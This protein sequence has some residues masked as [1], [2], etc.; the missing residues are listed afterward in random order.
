MIGSMILAWAACTGWAGA[1]DV[2]PRDGDVVKAVLDVQPAGDNLL[3]DDAWRPWQEGFTRQGDHFLCDNGA[4]AQ[5]QRGAS[6]SVMLNQTE[7]QPLVAV[8]W[9]RA[10]G[11]EGPGGGDYALYLDLVYR[12]GTP[13]WG[14]IAPFDRGTHD[15][16]RRQLVILPKKPIRSLSFHMLLR[17]HAGKAEF[18]GAELRPLLASEGAC[19]FDGV[20]VVPKQPPAEGF[21]VRDVA[22][23]SAF[24]RIEREALG[25]RL[26]VDPSESGDANVFDI[27]LSDTTG[28]DRAVTLVYAI[29]VPRK[30][31]TWF[32]DPRRAEP[33]EPRREYRRTGQFRAGANGELSRYPLAAVAAEGRATALAIDMT[34][35]AYFRLA[36]SSGTGEL[37]LAY[38]I[39]LTPEKPSVR[40][41]F[42]RY[43]FDA[44]WGFRSALA[45]YYEVFAAQFVTRAERQGL[46]MPFA[47]ISKVKGWE[48]FGFTFK[49][50][51][52]ETAW[53][54]A[55]GIVTFRY[56]EPMTWWMAMPA[57]APRTRE[58]ALAQARKL[59]DSG[60]ASAQ[61]LF[62]SGYHDA[63]GSFPA[64]LLDTPW[65]NGAV[66]SMN[67]MPGI[68]GEVTDFRNKWNP[69][70]RE[71]LYGPGRSGD[72][73][74]EYVD[75][76]EG[77]VT[78][79]LDYRRDHFAAADTPL[80]FSLDDRRPAIFRGLIAYEYVRGLARDVHAMNRLMMANGAPGQLCWLVPWLDVMGTETDWNPGG[81][82][83]PMSD[84]ELLYRRALTKGRPYCFLMNT[85][86]E[87]F[88]PE[89]VEKYMKRS[90]A[91]GMFPGFFSHNASQGHYFTRPELYDRDRPLFCKYVP[92]CRQVAE[93]G[94]QPITL[95]RSS[96]ERVYV[97][98]FG[99][100]YLTVF[101]DSE[102][103]RTAAIQLEGEC[104]ALIA[105]KTSRELVSGNTVAWRDGAT[106][107]TLGP[108]DVA[109][110]D[111]AAK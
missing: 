67:S 20:A 71:K 90:L 33:V 46:W 1:D 58:A 35:P 56:T 104:L 96:D 26:D 103:Q 32:A 66:W 102:S 19:L 70:L 12:D 15:W 86:F 57:D 100:R 97:E 39:G 111:L 109:L 55:H 64:R 89:L 93:A 73:D 11:V 107:L 41:R 72:L 3:H 87:R 77:Y 78:D 65:C 42:C 2:G 45:R 30:G 84:E 25:L 82:W 8:T 54:D 68:A 85:E 80:T 9:S 7:P 95:A 76:S 62:T 16:Q 22:A 28:R 108:E 60:N 61:A 50:G 49:E 63:A 69:E 4:E 81:R 47:P 53:D 105:D 13:D 83:R 31:L 98:R 75:S 21:Q 14:K 36:Y 94:W 38:D 43:P 10:E 24:V 40:V 48:D 99:Q 6:Q 88:G 92:L 52:G 23:G 101:N 106:R 17:N 37:Y 79:Q 91:Y 110:I 18:R 44:S 34:Q 59:A 51:N 74:G 5:V 29:P 27:E